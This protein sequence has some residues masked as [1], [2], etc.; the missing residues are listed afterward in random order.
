MEI[1]AAG[2]LGSGGLDLHDDRI[3]NGL[4]TRTQDASSNGHG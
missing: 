2:I 4:S 3:D 1:E